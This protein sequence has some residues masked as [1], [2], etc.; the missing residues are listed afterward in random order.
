MKRGVLTR[1][2]ILLLI[3]VL[4]L[5]AFL[6]VIDFLNQRGESIIGQI[7]KIFTFQF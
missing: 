7:A 2:A 5:V 6:F 3:A 4:T 1:E